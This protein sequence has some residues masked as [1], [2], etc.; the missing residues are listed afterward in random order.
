M[1]QASLSALAV[2]GGFQDPVLGSQ[3]A[4]RAVM[5]AFAAPGTIARLAASVEAPAPLAPA[6]AVFLLTLA[7]ADAS[8]FLEGA[9]A[10]AAAAWLG[11][12][13]GASL[14]AAPGEAAFALLTLGSDPAGWGRFGI[15]TDAYPDR[16]A[17]L[18][19]PVECLEG[20]APL[21]LTGPGIETVR[22]IAPQGLPAGFLAARAGNRALFPRG[23]DLVLVAGDGLIALPRSTRIAEA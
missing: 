17:T 15:G 9:E 23:H 21:V 8:I 16:A 20:G 12:H 5:D 11:F 6:A 7:D 14:V 13:T 2:S 1:T 3:D 4:F 10:G 22:T 18:I 19:L